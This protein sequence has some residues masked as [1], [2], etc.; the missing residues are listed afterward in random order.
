MSVCLLG[1]HSEIRFQVHTLCLSEGLGGQLEISL[2]SPECLYSFPNSQEYV[3]AYQGLL[4]LSHSSGHPVKFLAD[5]M[6]APTSIAPSASDSCDVGFPPLSCSALRW[7]LFY[8]CSFESGQPPLSFEQLFS[9]LSLTALVELLSQGPWW[10][11]I[12]WVPRWILQNPTVFL[13][14]YWFFLNN[15]LSLLYVIFQ[16]PEMVL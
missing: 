7:L 10:A 15:T 2:L 13:V 11:R 9:Q 14:V 12:F 6:I 8:A 1:P 4:W 16:S 5:F 3:G